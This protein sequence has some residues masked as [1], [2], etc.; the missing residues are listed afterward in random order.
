MLEG[1][2]GLTGLFAVGADIVVRLEGTEETSQLQTGSTIK[3]QLQ[4]NTRR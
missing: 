1:V 4:G 3:K 2:S